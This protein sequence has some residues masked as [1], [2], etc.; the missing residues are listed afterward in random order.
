MAT[1]WA[2]WDSRSEAEWLM[3]ANGKKKGVEKTPG[4]VARAERAFRG[5]ARELRSENKK[6]GLESVVWNNSNPVTKT[7]PM[8]AQKTTCHD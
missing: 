3:K 2:I 5:V 8:P 6:L 7:A 1:R 4:F